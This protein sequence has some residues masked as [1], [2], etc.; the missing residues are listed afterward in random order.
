[1]DNAKYTIYLEGGYPVDVFADVYE[2]DGSWFDF[3][4]KSEDNNY[5]KRR[6]VAS[7]CN[8]CGIVNNHPDESL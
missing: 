3:F 8:I 6:R 2:K 5:R 1:M 4:I 7:F